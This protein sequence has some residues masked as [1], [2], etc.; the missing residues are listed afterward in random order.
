M[1]TSFG[2]ENQQTPS[3]HGKPELK[4]TPPRDESRTG[5]KRMQTFVSQG[6][7]PKQTGASTKS[8]IVPSG[9]LKTGADRQDSIDKESSILVC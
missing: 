9:P 2:L 1:Y 7:R 4:K 8:D 6:A 5:D 3:Q